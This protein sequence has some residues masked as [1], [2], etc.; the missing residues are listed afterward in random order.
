[1]RSGRVDG[2]LHPGAFREIDAVVMLQNAADENRRRHRV[3]RNADALALQIFRFLDL[4]LV[5]ADEGVTEA[6]RGEYRDRDERAFLVGVA[7]HVFRAG[8]FGDV[9]LLA[10][11]HAVEDRARLLDADE[12]E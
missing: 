2:T 5:D 4:V 3:E 8:I 1:M 10:A 7:L 9:E 11:R 12:I 6:A